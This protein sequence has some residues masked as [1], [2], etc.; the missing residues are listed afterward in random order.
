MNRGALLKAE[1]STFSWLKWR[2][3]IGRKAIQKLR[4]REEIGIGYD[5]DRH[6]SRKKI[7]KRLWRWRAA[8][9]VLAKMCGVSHGDSSCAL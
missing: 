3:S 2:A 6:A 8:S 7:V 1:I 4:E 5:I 9:V